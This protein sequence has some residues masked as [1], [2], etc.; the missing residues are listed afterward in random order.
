MFSSFSASAS[1]APSRGM[2]GAA[3]C[4]MDNIISTMTNTY[5]WDT[6]R[7]RVILE[8][9]KHQEPFKK[10]LLALSQKAAASS[11]S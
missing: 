6:K 9:M 7:K 3:H 2:L 1:D 5:K 8:S 10:A 4:V 11:E